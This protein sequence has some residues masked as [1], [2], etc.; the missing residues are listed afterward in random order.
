MLINLYRDRPAVLPGTRLL[1]STFGIVGHRIPDP[2]NMRRVWEV[3]GLYM[4]IDGRTLGGIRA[5]MTDQKGF[6]SFCNQ[7]DLEVLLGMGV[8]G[9]FCPWA[10]GR[11]L[12]PDQEGWCGF[13]CDDD[14][15]LDD[16][17]DREML[18]RLQVPGGVLVP[19]AGLS[20]SCFDIER[21]VHLGGGNDVE[22]RFVLLGDYDPESGTFPD[23]RFE[24]V[25]RRW[26]RS[27]RKLVRWER[28][29]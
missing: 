23:T 26:I 1:E 11:Y 24:T 16:L 13:C 4:P 17:F 25:E 27:E 7:R 22:D 28:T 19:D 14:D 20:L 6:I 5:K 2:Y 3:Q 12:G 21:R 9:E 29:Q 15:L 8:P 10:G 18:M